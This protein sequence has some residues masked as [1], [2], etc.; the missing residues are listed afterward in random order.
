MNFLN[1]LAYPGQEYEGLSE[2]DK[3][4]VDTVLGAYR[5][6]RGNRR[7]HIAYVGMPIT[8]G[9][10]LYDVLE[11]EGL[12]SSAELR[13]KY[14]KKVFHDLVV[15]P[16]IKEG[17][18]LADRLGLSSN[19]LCIA[20][21]VFEAREWSQ[22]AYLSLWYRV[23]GELAGTHF[24]PKEWE[25]SLGAIKEVIFSSL[26]QWRLIHLGT[27]KETVGLFG[28]KNFH[29][30]LPPEEMEAELNAMSNIRIK[31]EDGTELSIDAALEKCVNA[32]EYL[33]H[34]GF[35]WRAHQRLAWQL[36]RVPIQSAVVH[37]WKKFPHDF[38]T[39]RYRDSSRKLKEFT[40]E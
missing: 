36:M 35:D 8:S 20:P 29:Q 4:G 1:D 34:R 31:S 21:S 28:L 23:I 9:K 38:A 6:F 30:D 3:S 16:N 32:I 33:D 22:E 12:R 18:E 7:Q 15:A 19:F 17:T 37:P 39:L 11:S 24:V 13:G 27:L 26:L 40:D 25:F 2:R 5:S 10:R 14:G